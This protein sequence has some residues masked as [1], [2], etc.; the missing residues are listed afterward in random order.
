MGLDDILPKEQGAYHR[1]ITKAERVEEIRQAFNSGANTLEAIAQQVGLSEGTVYEYVL[2][3]GIKL[4]EYKMPKIQHPKRR[5]EIDE[6][7]DK[8]LSLEA[9]GVKVG[10]SRE[11]I[12]IYINKTKHRGRE[13]KQENFCHRKSQRI[14]KE[15]TNNINM[16]NKNKF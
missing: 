12:R 15:F 2:V 11:N 8:G 6:M 10:N 16:E 13:S 3:S 1:R 5:P 4:P 14:I 9:M 7:I